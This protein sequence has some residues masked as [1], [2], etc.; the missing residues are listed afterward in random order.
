MENRWS[1]MEAARPSLVGTYSEVDVWRREKCLYGVALVAIVAVGVALLA[2]GTWGLLG[3]ALLVIGAGLV[4]K[5][6]LVYNRSRDIWPGLLQMY[7]DTAYD[8]AR[9][10]D[11]AISLDA[12]SELMKEANLPELKM[13]YDLVVTM[14]KERR[15]ATEDEK[16]QLWE[17]NDWISQKYSA[18]SLNRDQ[19]KVVLMNWIYLLGESYP[20]DVV[21]GE[22]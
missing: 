20:G 9:N 19:A 8:A 1:C 6:A 15:K 3:A 10:K 17:A 14:Q 16:R 2:T 5:I 12:L 11:W 18:S 21:R 13:A 22:E 4:A 7:K